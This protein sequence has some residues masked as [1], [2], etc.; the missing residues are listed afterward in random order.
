[1]NREELIILAKKEIDKL[2][3]DCWGTGDDGTSEFNS[4]NLDEDIL[5]LFIKLLDKQD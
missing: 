5:A 3:D 1:M 2:T 4:W